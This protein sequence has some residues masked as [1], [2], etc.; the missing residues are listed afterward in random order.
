MVRVFTYCLRLRWRQYSPNLLKAIE[1]TLIYTLDTENR[2]R[3]LADQFNGI[4]FDIRK[5]Q[6]VPLP[7]D[8]SEVM[9]LIKEVIQES[10]TINHIEYK[11]FLDSILSF[12]KE[13]E[14]LKVRS[15]LNISDDLK[16]A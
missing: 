14:K 13:E 9:Q 1:D 11:L 2:N 15:Q 3:D 7:S 6:Q 16:E 4:R 5:L 8:D 12:Y 10:F